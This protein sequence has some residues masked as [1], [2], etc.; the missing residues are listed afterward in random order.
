MRY[1]RIKGALSVLRGDVKL[2]N[3]GG[4]ER[5]PAR[6]GTAMQ[7]ARVAAMFRRL[8][9]SLRVDESL[10]EERRFGCGLRDDAAGTTHC[11]S[12]ASRIAG[13][14]LGRGASRRPRSAK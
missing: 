8:A 7:M 9:F 13:L 5:D 6:S 1:E 10:G 12:C 11:C 4:T 14:D 2:S 3:Y